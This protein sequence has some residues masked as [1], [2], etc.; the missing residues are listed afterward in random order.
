MYQLL[1]SNSASM[2]LDPVVLHIESSRF[3]S[4]GGLVQL[5]KTMEFKRS[6]GDGGCGEYTVAGRLHA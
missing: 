6:Y 5:S 1:A 3:R 4:A 2:K